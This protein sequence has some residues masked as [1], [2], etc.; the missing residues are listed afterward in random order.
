[1]VLLPEN[2]EYYYRR[3]GYYSCYFDYITPVR[4][5]NSIAEESLE[6]DASL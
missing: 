6:M 3:K 4:T 2:G 1:M 5:L